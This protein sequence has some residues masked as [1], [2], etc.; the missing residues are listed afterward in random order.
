MSKLIYLASPYSSGDPAELAQR[1][2][3][4]TDATARLVAKGHLIFSPIVHSHPLVPY[5]PTQDGG[6]KAWEKYDLAFID[7]ADEVWV[8]MLHGWWNSKG[9]RAELD[10]AKATGKTIRYIQYPNLLEFAYVYPEA[11]VVDAEAVEELSKSFSDAYKASGAWTPSSTGKPALPKTERL[12]DPVRTDNAM[13]YL[14]APTTAARKET[15]QHILIGLHGVAR[16]GKDTVGSYLIENHGFKR[17]SF[18]DP[19]RSGLLAIDPYIAVPITMA[20]LVYAMD[21][22]FG[23]RGV[24]ATA[25]GV[26]V[27]YRLS[28]LVKYL[29]WEKAKSIPDVRNLLQ[30]YG[31]EGGRDIHGK[32]CWLRVARRVIEDINGPVVITDV[33]FDNEAEFVRELGGQNW[34]IVRPG[35]GAVNAH[36]SDAGVALKLID[37]VIHNTYDIHHLYREVEEAINE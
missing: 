3:S 24:T 23:V 25:E 14:F 35:Y 10:H 21:V 7:K 29:G 5:M 26:F 19:V 15:P 33:R 17:V 9:I 18:A 20:D 22:A 34:Q 37:R 12:N 16:S 8:L 36:P 31:T 11:T 1:V 13:R 4:V 30:K 6:F 32:D 28:E 27:F 2:N